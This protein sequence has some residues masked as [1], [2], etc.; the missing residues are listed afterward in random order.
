MCLL[1]SNLSVYAN[2]EELGPSR[3][4]PGISIHLLKVKMNEN[5]RSLFFKSTDAPVPLRNHINHLII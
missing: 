4:T 1:G 3:D 2:P 5:Q